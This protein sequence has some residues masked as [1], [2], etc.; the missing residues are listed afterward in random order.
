MA[1]CKSLWIMDSSFLDVNVA[2]AEIDPFQLCVEDP[3]DSSNSGGTSLMDALSGWEN[4]LSSVDV[5]DVPTRVVVIQ[6]VEVR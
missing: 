3:I 4:S 5:V 6:K 2:S 1:S